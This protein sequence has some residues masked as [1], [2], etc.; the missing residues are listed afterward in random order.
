[1]NSTLLATIHLIVVNLFLLIYFIKTILLFANQQ[2]LQ[3]FTKTMRV[4]E[5]I[6]SALFLV[7]GVWL[8]VMLGAIKMLHI[9]KLVLIFISIPVAVI[10]FKKMNK[11]LALISFLLI[12]GAYGLAEMAK[13]KPFIPADVVSTGDEFPGFKIFAANCTMCHGTDGKKMYRGATDLSASALNPSLIPV[14]IREGSKGKMPAFSNTL[15]DEEIN[16]VTV[17]V[18]TLRGK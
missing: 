15:T 18:Q 2:A 17:Y 16:A 4:P 7:T 5:M 3:K 6:V 10:G 8:F 13:S 14:M 12:V 9:I 11:A 1:M